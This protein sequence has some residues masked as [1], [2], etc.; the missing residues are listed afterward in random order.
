MAG[1]AMEGDAMEDYAM[2]DGARASDVMEGHEAT[3]DLTREQ[4]NRV[5]ATRG[6][7]TRVRG[8]ESGRVVNCARPP[9]Y[10]YRRGRYGSDDGSPKLAEFPWRRVHLFGDGGSGVE[11]Q[12][13]TTQG[14]QFPG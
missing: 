3:R 1:D 2:Y 10:R 4:A 11:A 7:A 9:H 6:Q 12:H 5:R 8:R 14:S 13:S